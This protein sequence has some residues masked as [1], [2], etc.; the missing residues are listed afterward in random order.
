MIVRTALAGGKASGPASVPAPIKRK[1]AVAIVVVPAGEGSRL[2]LIRRAERL[3]DPWS[4]QMAF[5]GGHSEPQDADSLATAIRETME[6]VGLRLSSGSH[7]G[8]LPA[9][10]ATARGLPTGTLITPHVFALQEAKSLSPNLKEVAAT[11]WAPM[12]P[13]ARGEWDAVKVLDHEGQRL[14]LPA[15]AVEGNLVWGLTHR[16]LREF[17]ALLQKITDHSA[18]DRQ[19]TN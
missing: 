6:E 19:E 10:Q 2:L 14:S 16:M 13:M 5:P 4:G 3:G 18:G 9:L 11:Y 7:L 15:I 17:F 1:A 8:A 12:G